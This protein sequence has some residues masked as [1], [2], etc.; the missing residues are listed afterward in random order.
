MFVI[1]NYIDFILRSKR[2]KHTYIKILK[3]CQIPDCVMVD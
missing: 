1:I 2:L 3:I